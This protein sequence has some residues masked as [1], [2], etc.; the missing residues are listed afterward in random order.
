MTPLDRRLSDQLYALDA[1]GLLRSIVPTQ[2]LAEGRIEVDGKQYIN[3]AG[4]DYLGLCS[5]A[6]LFRE[7]YAGLIS[8]DGGGSCALGSGASRLMTGSSVPYQQ[9]EDTLARLYGKESALVFNSGWQ[10][11][12][13]VLSALVRK[14]D[15]VVA[16]RLCHASLIDGLRLAPARLIRYPHL[17]YERLEKLL[18]QHCGSSGAVF[19][20]TES[21]FSM[22]GDCADL[23]ALAALRD[24]YGAVLYVDEAHAVG[25]R[26][27]RGLGLAEEQG[28]LDQIDLLI[29]TFGKAWAGQGAFIVGSRLLRDFL[30]NTARTLIFTTALPPASIHWL[31]VVL[32]KIVAMT[33]ERLR[34]TE[35]ADQ[36]RTRLQQLGL[37]TDGASQ[38]VPVMIGDSS[39]AVEVAARLRSHGF[40]VNAVR[41]PT[42]PLNTARL[43]LSLSA[44]MSAEQ[45]IALP[46]LIAEAMQS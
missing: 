29:G 24:K 35:L 7:F 25:V 9:L 37:I 15:F 10:L 14:G 22:D 32:P 8:D 3:L 41:P 21:I 44:A 1:Q 13:G 19:I 33:A 4:N 5:N 23:R 43:R 45:L 38:I 42:V 17:D 36:L 31:N 26:G 27:A 20:V 2:P 30:V 11:N 16:D 6:A 18:Q 39:R 28:V 40:W 34:L 46:E 12:T